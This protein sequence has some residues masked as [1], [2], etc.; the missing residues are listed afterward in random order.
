MTL[1]E[2]LAIR[3]RISSRDTSS[4]IRRLCDHLGIAFS[5]NRVFPSLADLNQ[6]GRIVDEIEELNAIGKQFGIRFRKMSGSL[7][8]LIQTVGD[9]GPVLVRPAFGLEETLPP[10]LVL[11]VKSRSRIVV[12]QDSQDRIES[13][14]WLRKRLQRNS[15]NQYEWLLVQ[16]MLAA[17]SAS[18]F[19]YQTG[20]QSEPLKPLKR[21]FALLKPESSDV[22]TIVVFS[23]VIGLL[24]LTLPLAVE[25]VVNT[26]A[27]GR[28]LQPLIVLS[29]I[30]F[31]FLGFRAGLSVLMTI[32]TE[33]IQRK[34]FVRTVED[35][36]YRLTRVP[37]SVWRAKHGPEL[38]NRFF[39][40][41]TIQ[42]VTS[43]LLLETL[44][45]VL[46]TVIGLSVLAF[47]HPFLLGYDIGLLAMMTLVLYFIGRGAIR[48]AT[49]E[50]QL[51]YETAAWLQEIVRHPSTYKFNGGLGFAINRADE[52]AAQYINHRESHFRI[53]I[54]QFTFAMAMQ[55]VAA[56]VLLALGGYL[57][58]QGQMTLGQLVAAEL[59]VTVILGSFAKFG[60]DLESFYDLMA[61][62]DKIGKLFDLPVEPVDKL[63]L[64]RHPG[65]Y[66]V[67]LVDAKLNPTASESANIVF[68]SGRS[69]AIYCATELTRGKLME[70]LVGQAKPVSGHVLLNDY[71][72]DAIA[73]ESLQEKISLIRDIELFVGTVDDNLRMGRRNVGSA[74]ANDVVYRLGFRNTLAA[75]PDGLATKLNISGYPLSQ[76][77]AIRLVIARA[78]IA[79][80]GI[81]FI[82]GLV[83]RLSDEDI[84][85]LLPRLS[86]F[87]DVTTIILATGRQRVA[88]WADHCLDI[89]KDPWRLV[90]FDG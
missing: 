85:D 29:S 2:T 45:L 82:D 86:T 53:L 14:S 88:R 77:Q 87:T 67:S 8:D 40:I 49:D 4:V 12:S 74:D 41:V 69:H 43:K 80:P 16:P 76:G 42:K 3:D 44:M 55:V 30:V 78:L 62:V 11:E 90:N 50:S 83:D 19:Y 47:Y 20:T 61:S 37:L 28:Y 57:V 75:L 60:K 58:I 32:V 52:L 33:I 15:D 73:A 23:I 31:I 65:A 72:V 13:P 59:I 9:S 51:K 24:S 64:A 6:N 56:T 34:L 63:Q 36:S 46:Q 38:V 18:R 84:E 5:E 35:L 54:R 81:L 71:R 1:S 26:I 68:Q 22:R 89:R 10:A 79:K 7:S 70:V 17:E 27:F 21:L 25:A 66:E 48:T 39:D